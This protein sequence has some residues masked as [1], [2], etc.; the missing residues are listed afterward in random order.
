MQPL[1]PSSENAAFA[2]TVNHMYPPTSLMS[3]PPHQLSDL[4]SRIVY[5]EIGIVLPV[6]SGLTRFSTATAPT[7]ILDIADLARLFA[8]DPAVFWATYT[9]GIESAYIKHATGWDPTTR[10]PLAVVIPELQQATQSRFFTQLL[11][12]TTQGIQNTS[13]AT[14][15][16]FF[17]QRL[18]ISIGLLDPI[19]TNPILYHPNVARPAGGID[20]VTGLQGNPPYWLSQDITSFTLRFF[21][22]PNIE[23]NVK[24]VWSH[25][26]PS[27][28]SALSGGSGTM[29]AAQAPQVSGGAGAMNQPNLGAGGDG[30][31]AVGMGGMGG[32]GTYMSEGGGEQ[33]MG[34]FASDGT[35]ST[36]PR[37]GRQVGEELMLEPMRREGMAGIFQRAGEMLPTIE[38]AVGR[39]APIAAQI[40]T[41]GLV[42][43]QVGRNTGVIPGGLIRPRN[44][45]SFGPLP[46][47]APANPFDEMEELGA[48]FDPIGPATNI[49][50]QPAG[51]TEATLARP[52]A[53]IV[54]I[55][56]IRVE[57]L[58]A[59]GD[60]G[61]Q[62][63]QADPAEAP[64]ID[65]QDGMADA[66]P[67]LSAAVA[68]A[69]A[70]QVELR[71]IPTEGYE[72]PF[73]AELVPFRAAGGLPR[74]VDR[75]FVSAHPS[76]SVPFD[77]QDKERGRSIE[78]YA[79]L[80]SHFVGR[81]ASAEEV[82]AVSSF[83]VL[84]ARHRQPAVPLEPRASYHERVAQFYSTRILGGGGAPSIRDLE[85][86]LGIEVVSENPE[87]EHAFRN[88]TARVLSYM[89]NPRSRMN[90]PH[91]VGAQRPVP[92][93]PIRMSVRRTR[94]EALYGGAGITSSEGEAQPPMKFRAVASG[95]VSPQTEGDFEMGTVTTPA[96]RRR[97]PRRL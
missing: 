4:N 14:L 59:W 28:T 7:F 97:G 49:Y 3:L 69:T 19:P 63:H 71:G 32:M 75:G 43:Y 89:M 85:E 37:E 9:F 35:A 67:Q 78:S 93:P 56:D 34:M 41:A 6:P 10:E 87:D 58:Q 92:R 95:A 51:G 52:P 79:R 48:E 81:R 74:S 1:I 65:P 60:A 61:Q 30:G 27:L 17:P 16:N 25:V 80:I 91:S 31:G 50:M 2:A 42:A 66:A 8:V 21:I 39:Y 40:G 90:Q 46:T 54:G 11:T 20:P 13:Q 84:N 55:D 53:G 33:I 23:V 26:I 72:G 77:S 38:R 76:H 22:K 62:A 15:I 86:A 64:F 29:I 94:E 96:G 12:D 70:D 45:I 24:N 73:G 88:A 68:Q 57:Q 5:R 83:A 36:V 82:T 44:Q 18:T 47:A